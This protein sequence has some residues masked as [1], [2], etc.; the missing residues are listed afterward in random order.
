MFVN[1]QLEYPKPIFDVNSV[2]SARRLLRSRQHA[3]ARLICFTTSGRRICEPHT[4][5][6]LRHATCPRSAY[7]ETSPGVC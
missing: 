4:G 7:G 5:H 6:D 2:D 3:D 1:S